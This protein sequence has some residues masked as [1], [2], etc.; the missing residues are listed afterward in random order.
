[1]P[2]VRVIT[3]RAEVDAAII[4]IMGIDCN[5]FTQ[6]AMIAQGDFQKL[7]FAETGERKKIFR[8][9]FHT[10]L[11]ETIQDKL[12]SDSLSL[13][14]EYAQAVYSVN[15]YVS[16]I[17]CDEDD[18]LAIDVRKAQE[19]GLPFAEI[20][21]LLEKIIK[22]DE[23]KQGALQKQSEENQKKK[24][25]LTKILAKAEEVEK[26]AGELKTSRE[27]LDVLVPKLK[28]LVTA[29]DTE[30][31]KK[32]EQEKLAKQIAEIE[33]LLPEYGELEEK[34]KSLKEYAEKIEQ[35]QTRI[36]NGNIVKAQT[37]KTI[38]ELK[39]EQKALEGA[40]GRKAKLEAE[41]AKT[42]D[43]LEQLNALKEDF[44]Q[45]AQLAQNFEEAQKKYKQAADNYD[46][47]KAEYEQ[48][49]RAYLCLL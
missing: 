36:E 46:K 13:K 18:V 5:Q 33:A 42:A 3:K 45:Y 22:S 9:I 15:Q 37:E 34:Q 39:A 49:N 40:D 19:G 17:V 48:A 11:Y 43:I 14:N 4:E 44:A 7:L 38:S 41:R 21:E 28:E 16:G 32:P 29:R 35:N 26:A 12:K 25:G 10:D 27:Q 1:M 24:D 20:S 2:D 23:E 8:K 6:I 47:K 30:R 31:A